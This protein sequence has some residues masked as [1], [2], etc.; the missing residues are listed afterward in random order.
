MDASYYKLVVFSGETLC[1]SEL[2]CHGSVLFASSYYV[3]YF[4]M[5]G[6]LSGV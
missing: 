3:S 1:G 6:A 4:G 2:L 5:A